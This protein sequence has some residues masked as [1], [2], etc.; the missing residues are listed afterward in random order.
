MDILMNR[1]AL[2]T[3]MPFDSTSTDGQIVSTFESSPADSYIRSAGNYLPLQ[4]SGRGV[5]HWVGTLMGC[6][7]HIHRSVFRQYLQ[8]VVMANIIQRLRL[9]FYVTTTPQLVRPTTWP[10]VNSARHLAMT[11]GSSKHAIMDDV[12]ATV[13]LQHGLGLPGSAAS[14]GDHL[15][16]SS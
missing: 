3:K 12:S 4:E 7:L 9:C 5:R 15:P 11:W 1:I 13:A 16:A 2:S 10:P 8:S 14:P 6:T